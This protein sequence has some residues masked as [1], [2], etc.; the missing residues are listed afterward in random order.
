MF[1]VAALPLL[2]HAAPGPQMNWC[3][4]R[5]ARIRELVALGDLHE[6][7]QMSLA[8]NRSIDEHLPPACLEDLRY[9]GIANIMSLSDGS[10]SVYLTGD[11]V[12]TGAY[13]CYATD[14]WKLFMSSSVGVRGFTLDGYFVMVW[15][16]QRHPGSQQLVASIEPGSLKTGVRSL[17]HYSLG[18]KTML[19]IPLCPGDLSEA[20]C[21]STFNRHLVRTDFGGNIVAYLEAVI[22]NANAFFSSASR[23]RFQLKATILSPVRLSGYGSASCGGSPAVGW[24][25]WSP[26]PEALDTQ[27][28]AQVARAQGIDRADFDFGAILLPFCDAFKWSGL[29]WIGQPGFAINLVAADLDPSFVHEIGHNLGLNHGT[30]LKAGERGRAIWETAYVDSRMPS[31]VG[32]HMEYGSSLTPMGQGSFPSAHYML[33]DK[34]VLEWASYEAIVPIVAGAAC[35]PCGPYLLQPLDTGSLSATGLA[36]IRIATGVEGRFFWVEHRT[37]APGG[38]AAVM[39]SASYDATIGFGGVVGKTVMVDTLPTDVLGDESRPAIYPAQSIQLDIGAKGSPSPMWLDVARVVDGMLEVSIR[40]TPLDPPPLSPPPPPRPISPPPPLPPSPRQPAP[41][42]PTSPPPRQPPLPSFPLQ[43]PLSSPHPN[44]PPSALPLLAPA[45]PSPSLPPPPLESLP[46]PLAP[47]LL[48]AP[49][50]P[51]PISPPWPSPPPLLGL[52][53]AYTL[54]DAK[55]AWLSTPIGLCIVVGAAVVTVVNF[56]LAAAILVRRA[57][58]HPRMVKR[59][60]TMPGRTTARAN[61]ASYDSSVGGSWRASSHFG[62]TVRLPGLVRTSHASTAGGCSPASSRADAT[63]DGCSPALSR[64]DGPWSR[65]SDE[66][67]SSSASVCSVAEPSTSP[68]HAGRVGVRAGSNLRFAGGNRTVVVSSPADSNPVSGLRLGGSLHDVVRISAPNAALT[69]AA[70]S[71]SSPDLDD[72]VQISVPDSASSPPSPS[73]DRGAGLSLDNIMPI[74]TPHPALS[75]PDPDVR[76]SDESSVDDDMG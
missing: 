38:S 73:P 35:E 46:V 67:R 37:I 75:P 74:W 59:A 11:P 47:S 30:R 25:S 41:A 54:P 42:P 36:G 16:E 50:P 76:S 43:S 51:M 33:P 66:V 71:L 26:N 7:M 20:E 49:P 57:S 9:D 55:K 58:R 4:N 10:I 15:H 52:G 44:V 63:A 72:V 61:R 69:G 8:L 34:A 27:V 23:S 18:T 13:G 19:V 31:P 17:D 40:T 64:A 12:R 56:I 39:C 3:N 62:G 53:L 65:D 24:N 60:K 29:G 70:H 45:W 21:A 22:D 68:F 32:G 14:A 6:A 28:Y 48:S 1:A 2:S 5:L